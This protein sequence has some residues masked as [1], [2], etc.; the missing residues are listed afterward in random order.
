MRNTKKHMLTKVILLMIAF[1]GFSLEA[2]AARQ[3]AFVTGGF[4]RS[5]NVKNIEHLAK[6]GKAR[7]LLKDLLKF[8]NQDPEKIS[9]LLNQEVELPIVLTS[10]L[11]NSKIGEAILG[12]VAKVIHPVKVSDPKVAIPAIRAGI[13]LGIAER[14]NGLTAVDFMKA[15]P[16]DVMAISIPE[17]LKVVDKVNS[18][19]DLIKFFSSSP[20]EKL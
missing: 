16:T 5:V 10:R 4:R 1:H 15:Y 11:I 17:L 20:L 13:I 8:G 7:G 2:K 3:V 12:R 18:V 14:G 9:G 6:T 19:S